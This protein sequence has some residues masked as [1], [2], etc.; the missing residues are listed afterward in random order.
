[1][2]PHCPS[3]PSLTPVLQ[4]TEVG[5]EHRRDVRALA[6]IGVEVQTLQ[7]FNKADFHLLI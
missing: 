6:L 2:V 1:M 5:P 4:S 7:K 3:L